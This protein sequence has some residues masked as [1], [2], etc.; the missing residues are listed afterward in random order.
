MRWAGK[1]T[2]EKDHVIFYSCQKKDNVFGTGF[3]VH[4][5]IKHLVVGFKAKTPRLCRLRITGQ[6]STIALSAHT[7]QLKKRAIKKRLLL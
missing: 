1:G 6:F 2:V 7:P 5:K 3:I 4:K